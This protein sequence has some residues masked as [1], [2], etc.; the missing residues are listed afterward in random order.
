MSTS[1]GSLRVS[2]VVT[3][4][5]QV[6]PLSGLYEALNSFELLASF[7][8]DVPRRPF[9][10]ELVAPDVTEDPPLSRGL[11]IQPHRTCSEISGTDLVVVPLMMVENAEWM[12]GRHPGVVEWL[13]EMHRGGATLCSTCTGVLLLAETGLLSGREATIHWAFAPTFRRN[14]PDVRLRPEEALIATGDRHD[15]VMTGGVVSW[16]DLALYL[17]ARHVGSRAAHAM[18]RL[19]ML[20]WHAEGQAPYIGF[21][22]ET[23]HGDALVAQLQEWLEGHFEVDNPVAEM[24]ERSGLARRTL[25]RRFTRATGYSPIRYV[26]ALRIEHAKRRLEDTDQPI[27]Q[28]SYDIGYY[29]VAYFRRL[30]RARTRLTPGAYR[31]KFSLGSAAE[32]AADVAGRSPHPPLENPTPPAGQ[33]DIEAETVGRWPPARHAR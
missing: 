14:F 19:L 25:E 24:V 30:F 5:T 20:Q 29:N 31:R 27:E 15:L 32:L 17:I 13:I 12:T 33:R 28:I 10:I 11:S 26:Q 8:P 22:P 18:A 7:E 16:H 9:D 3:P 1:N 6:G 2:L 4:D 23:G 21:A